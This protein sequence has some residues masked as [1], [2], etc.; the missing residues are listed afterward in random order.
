MPNNKNMSK[1]F[2]KKHKNLKVKRFLFFLLLAAI[3]WVLTKFSREFTA[4]MVAKIQYENVP[5]NAA[6]SEGNL[7]SITFDLT[8]NGF[9]ILFYK[10]KRPTIDLQINK[11]YNKEKDHFIITKS[12]LN[13]MVS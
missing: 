8:A 5:E 12:E 7:K 11:Y 2:F 6:L 4:T 3:F 9:E 13:R 10:F 1:G